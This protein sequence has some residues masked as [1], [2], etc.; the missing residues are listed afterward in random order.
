MI[1]SDTL[2]PFLILSEISLIGVPLQ[3]WVPNQ[4]AMKMLELFSAMKLINFATTSLNIFF[5]LTIA[6]S[7]IVNIFATTHIRV[8]SKLQT[9]S[10]VYLSRILKESTIHV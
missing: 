3:F 2:Y 10:S 5:S 4:F 9:Q 1:Y 6:N 8:H 7:A